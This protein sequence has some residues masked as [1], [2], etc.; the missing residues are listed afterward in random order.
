M[1]W[2]HQITALRYTESNLPGVRAYEI[3]K[4]VNPQQRSDQSACMRYQARQN[5][6][7]VEQV[8]ELQQYQLGWRICR[9]PKGFTCKSSAGLP[10]PSE[11]QETGADIY[12][13]RG[14]PHRRTWAAFGPRVPVCARCVTPRAGW[15]LDWPSPLCSQSRRS[16]V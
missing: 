11:K 15:P 7:L 1:G 16:G 8:S 5:L 13:R 12:L 3:S 9:Q 6:R 2:R 4:A 10:P 14:D